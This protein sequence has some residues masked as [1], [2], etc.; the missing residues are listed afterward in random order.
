MSKKHWEEKGPME[1]NTYNKYTK[2]EAD[3]PSALS[4]FA[5]EPNEEL[6]TLNIDMFLH[7]NIFQGLGRQYYT[8]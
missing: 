4:F 8:G 6:Q 1:N 7:I 5:S 3:I 2:D